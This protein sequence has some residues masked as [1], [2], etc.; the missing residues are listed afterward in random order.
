MSAK[1]AAAAAAANRPWQPFIRPEQRT[2]LEQI[3]RRAGALWNQAIGE[4]LPKGSE[5]ELEDLQVGPFAQLVTGSMEVSLSAAFE[6][7]RDI[8]GQLGF[9]AALA[10]LLLDAPLPGQASAP[11]AQSRPFS[12]IEQSVLRRVLERLQ[13]QLGVAYQEA[14]I[15]A[16]VSAKEQP[17]ADGRGLFGPDDSVMVATYKVSDRTSRAG[18]TIVAGSG[19]VAAVPHP[20]EKVERRR[21]SI[22]V[23][24][25]VA[26]LP[27]DLDVVLG[28]WV[29]S[30]QDLGAL[31]IGDS[32]VLPDGDDAWL[33]AR[34]VRLMDA[35]AKVGGRRITVEVKSGG[36]ASG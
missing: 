34:G 22:D 33:E 14:G 27:I 25:A 29:V 16:L 11:A 28:T 20:A 7:N 21:G 3:H 23:A 18:I 26:L 6:L 9:D 12:K 35:Q 8:R 24:N 13:R 10:Q 2:T 31:K 30:L 4:F 17:Q 36:V 32:I 19:I 5:V 15:G 1:T